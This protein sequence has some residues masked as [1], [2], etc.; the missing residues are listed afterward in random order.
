MARRLRYFEKKRG[1]RRTGSKTLGSAGEAV[2]FAVLLLIGCG[3]L[4]AL[5]LLL[6]VPE[7]RVNRVFVE[8]TCKVRKTEIQEKLNGESA[9]YQARVNVRHEVDGVVYGAWTYDIATARDLASSYS[10]RRQDQQEVLDRFIIDREYSCWYDPADP[11]L[12]VLVRGYDWWIWL[13]LIIPVSS[14]VVGG[15]GVLYSVLHWGK[16]AE[17]RAAMARRA[18]QHDLLGANGRSRREFPNIPDDSDITN[19][20]GTRLRFRLPIGASPG[21]ALFGVFVACLLVNG[22]VSLLALSAVRSHLAGEPDWLLTLFTIPF[23]L[24]G[25]GLM[26]FFVQQLLLTTGIGPTRVEIS[27]HPLHAGQH[28]RLFLSQSGRLKVKSLTVLLICE[29]AATYL[30]E[31][32]GVPTVARQMNRYAAAPAQAIG[33]NYGMLRILELRQEANEQLGDQ[34]DIRQFH[35]VVLGRGQMP[36]GLLEQVVEEWIESQL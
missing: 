25:I 34:F 14:I 29:E 18:Q 11:N 17:R 32:T 27:D 8:N 21:W 3:A 1:N 22:I 7:W 6:V 33:F 19:S 12:V 31:A 36:I 13:V 30:E 4:A 5:V 2:F 16:S 24:A 20:P 35:D 23:V 15:G 26:V 9:T 10:S 28:C